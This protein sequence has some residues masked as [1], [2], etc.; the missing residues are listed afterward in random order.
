MAV[1][2][3]E[4][5]SL[6]P[7]QAGLNAGALNRSSWGSSTPSVSCGGARLAKTRPVIPASAWSRL[8]NFPTHHACHPG[9]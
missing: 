7:S 2:L 5:S 3:A 1:T 4:P 8:R 6:T 9:T